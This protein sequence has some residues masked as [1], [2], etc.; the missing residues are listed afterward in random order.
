MVHEITRAINNPPTTATGAI[1]TNPSS[2]F[3]KENI[4]LDKLIMISLGEMQRDKNK[5]HSYVTAPPT[6]GLSLSGCDC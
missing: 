2:S 4:V 3:T 1:K 6:D 5:Q